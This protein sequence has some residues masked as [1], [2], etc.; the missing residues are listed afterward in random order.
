LILW[1]DCDREGE[2][3]AFEVLN[4]CRLAN[5]RIEVFRAHFSAVT[6]VDIAKVMY[7]P[8]VGS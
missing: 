1:L 4:V 6:K 5:P 8:I 7:H 3:I 2:N